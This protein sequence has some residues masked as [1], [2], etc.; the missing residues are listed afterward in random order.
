MPKSKSRKTRLEN[1]LKYGG[2][3]LE[4]PSA[5]LPT[6]RQVIQFFYF[7]E[8]NNQNISKQNLLEKVE[9]SLSTLWNK[10]NPRLPLLQRNSILRKLRNL[11]ERVKSINRG[12]CKSKSKE[13][14]DMILDELFDI[15]SCNCELAT[16]LCNDRDVKCSI[17][18]CQVE[19]ILC[20]CK[21][22]KV[23]SEDRSYI[24]DQRSKIGPK[25]IYQLGKTNLKSGTFTP[26]RLG[27]V[28]LIDHVKMPHAHN[29]LIDSGHISEVSASNP[30]VLNRAIVN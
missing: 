10:V 30:D 22:R 29:S 11:F 1:S 25:G 3:P 7:T 20:L 6:F 16:V 23:P 12:R 9:N 18:N 28:E 27:Q 8:S 13:Y 19:H 2:L 15:P 17:I 5:D 26:E 14:Q 4:M 21:T 24:R